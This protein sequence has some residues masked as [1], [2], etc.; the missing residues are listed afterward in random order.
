[1]LCLFNGHHNTSLEDTGEP[2]KADDSEI[3]YFLQDLNTLPDNEKDNLV[4]EIRMEELEGIIGRYN[5][6]KS[7]GL[8]GLCYEFYQE[9]FSIVK[10]DLLQILQC[11]LDRSR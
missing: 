10:Y 2:F 4:K 8:D 11:Q 3:N 5:R 9:T 6:N 7:P 1:M